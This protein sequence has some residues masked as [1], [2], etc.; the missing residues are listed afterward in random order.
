MAL[1]TD[2][3]TKSEAKRTPKVFA[4]SGMKEEIFPGFFGEGRRKTTREARVLPDLF[5]RSNMSQ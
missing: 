2:P 4:S 3:S 5:M 1:E